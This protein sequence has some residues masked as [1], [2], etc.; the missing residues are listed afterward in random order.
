LCCRRYYRLCGARRFAASCRMW[1][2]V[3]F[4]L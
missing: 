3:S 4:M 2:E 1:C